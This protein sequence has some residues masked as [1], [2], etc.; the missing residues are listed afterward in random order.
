MDIAFYSSLDRLF[1]YVILI[2]VSRFFL[3]IWI[4]NENYKIQSFL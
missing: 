1:Q 2:Y 4:W 3:I